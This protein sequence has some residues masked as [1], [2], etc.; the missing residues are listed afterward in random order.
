[1]KKATNERINKRTHCAIEWRGDVFVHDEQLVVVRSAWLIYPHLD[2]L[3]ALHFSYL[4]SPPPSSCEYNYF[5]Y[6]YRLF[7]F[8]AASSHDDAQP[9]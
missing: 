6:I 8:A 4:S 2:L 9:T 3:D 5:K 7:R 1:M